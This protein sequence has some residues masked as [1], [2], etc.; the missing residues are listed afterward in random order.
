M[1]R[2]LK[3][4]SVLLS[5]VMLVQLVPMDAVAQI[6]EAVIMLT[7][8]EAAVAASEPTTMRQNTIVEEPVEILAEIESL[9][10]ESTKHFRNMDGSYSAILYAEPVHFQDEHG[11]WRDIDNS[12]QL[13]DSR[14]SASGKAS[15]A[16]AGNGF[17]IRVPQEFSD[18][19][20]LTVT[21]DGFTVGLGISARNEAVDLGS[22]AAVVAVDALGSEVIVAEFT[23]AG[24]IAVSNARTGLRTEAE[25]IQEANAEIIAL[26]GSLNSAVVYE[27]IFPGADLEY[28]ITPTRIKE[29]IV[30][31][32]AQ[33]EYIYHFTLSYDGLIPVPQEDGAI[34]L[35]RDV[36]D[37]EPLFELEAPFMFDAA[38][39]HSRAL[40]M[41]LEGNALTLIADAAWINAE[42][43][44]FPV[45]IDPTLVL[46]RT[47]GIQEASVSSLW[48]W[49]IRDWDNYVGRW[50]GNSLDLRRTYIRFDL[51]NLPDASVVLNAT[52]ALYQWLGTGSA[53]NQVVVYDCMNAAW[54]PTGSNS[55]TWNNQPFPNNL[56]NVPALD[57]ACTQVNGLFP[58]AFHRFHHWDITKAAKRW[59]EN[60]EA[61]NG[62]M[63]AM[64]DESANTMV[65]SQSSRHLTTNFPP[66]LQIT[67]INNTGL[68]PYWDYETVSLGRFGTAFVNT[69]NGDL[70]YA[71]NTIGLSGNL[72]PLNISHVYNANSENRASLPPNM[73]LGVGFSMNLLE[74]IVP[75]PAGALRDAGFYYKHIDGDGTVHYYR[76]IQNN[77]FLHEFNSSLRLSLIDGNTRFRLEDDQGNIKLFDNSNNIGR[78]TEIRDRNSAKGITWNNGRITQVIDGASRPALFEYNSFNQLISFTDPANRSITFT[79]SSTA[80]NATLTRI[81]F[82][83]NMR[84]SFQYSGGNLS[85]IIAN[86]GTGDVR[87]SIQYRTIQSF[88]RPF[89]RVNQITQTPKNSS[90]PAIT[91]GFEY[92]QGM[93]RVTERAG[94]GREYSREY[95]FDNAGRTVNVRNQD[96]QSAFALYHT[97]GDLN[98]K[99]SMTAAT[100]AI[101]QNL[102]RNHGF[103]QGNNAHWTLSP[104]ASRSSAYSSRGQFSMRMANNNTTCWEHVHQGFA[105]VP[106]QTYTLSAD[107]L[108]PSPL[109]GSG[110]V[111]L[112]FGFNSTGGWSHPLGQLAS[113]RKTVRSEQRK[114]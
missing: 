35:Y 31:R 1:K 111:V 49:T 100:Q 69:Y 104:T 21:K 94:T 114:P 109:Q 101:A 26:S 53:A 24:D 83:G 38:G 86:D 73:R 75:V 4:L 2:L 15:L 8:A 68:E 57:Y 72:M 22:K 60:S 28:I 89:F 55:I 6:P 3:I 85:N 74:R 98:N 64:R 40:A 61:N 52:L 27:N 87:V 48:P 44:V 113:L 19:Q 14:L 18:G 13:N 105:A 46:S 63:L 5:F 76:R 62:I 56:T 103:E 36:S 88:G 108:I 70:T 59:Y 30:L 91:M 58:I 106:G 29:N 81:N 95:I 9:R 43:R 51:P 65:F 32:E 66:M 67:Y 92:R 102:L 33:D 54:S 78:L 80:A 99:P 79:Y 34:H 12:L 96:G 23:N 11:V 84:T 16:P 41:L 20:K 110:G 25:R 50:P 37:A 42:E 45:V 77:V 7:A 112:G 90:T 47:T 39:E 107:I 93:T 82:P 17:D 71:V 10:N 97:N